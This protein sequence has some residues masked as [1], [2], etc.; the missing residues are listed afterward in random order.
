MN[1]KENAVV[2]PAGGELSAEQ[3]ARISQ[4]FRA[5]K[6]LLARKRPRFDSGAISCH[7]SSNQKSEDEKET[8]SLVQVDG[9]KRVP[10][11]KIS[12]NISSQDPLNSSMLSNWSGDDVNNGVKSEI[13]LTPVRQAECRSRQCVGDASSSANELKDEGFGVGKLGL[14][15]E[16]GSILNSYGSPSRQHVS[17]YG[18]KSSLSSNSMKP[19][20]FPDMKDSILTS[21]FLGDDFEESILEEIDALCEQKS[22]GN[23]E[24][25]D[26]IMNRTENEIIVKS[27]EEDVVITNP[28]VSYETLKSKEILNSNVDQAFGVE[29]VGKSENKLTKNMPEEYAKYI[30]SLNDKQQEAACSDISIPLVIVAG[31]GSGKTSTMVGRVLMLL[32]EGISPSN[33]LAMTFTT[34]A[35]AEMRERIG[36]I[37]G[38]AAAKELTIS[39]FH[40]FSLQLCRLHAEKHIAGKKQV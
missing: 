28:Q 10:L 36:A 38:K 20:V 24:R 32:Y 34:A 2:I 22:S 21:N 15:S 9:I 35:A 33:I 19:L 6:A 16:D 3:R 8:K 7:L 18:F 14:L 27:C 5:A 13:L 26:T 12:T 29:W 4:S 40:S 11:S 30:Q 1:N 31:P 25:D 17:S 37:A 23:S 39:T